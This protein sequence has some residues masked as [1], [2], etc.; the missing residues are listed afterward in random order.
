MA[1][2]PLDRIVLTLLLGGCLLVAGRA[3][4]RDH[5]EHDPWTPLALDD[6]AG[7]ATSRKIA[8]LRTERAVCRAFLGR[9]GIDATALAPAGE[10]S[11]RRDDRKALA[12]P[13]WLDIALRPG[14]A[15]ATCAIDAG[16]AWW[17]HN[18]VQPA[19]VATLGTRVVRVEH[20]G[21]ANCRRIG[22]GDEGTWSEHATGNA[23]DIAAFVLADGRRI[24]VRR[25]W[26][27][28]G[29]SGVEASAFLHMVRDS[30]CAGF[31]TVLSPDYNAAHAD[32]LHLDQARRA[33]GWSACR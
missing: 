25:D 26:R 22:G 16:L 6:P 15:Q 28:R 12:A 24:S 20:L 11:C 32:H 9:S 14:G 27:A 1:F 2:A 10:G 30:A 8:A 18:G 31:A 13:A 4:L 23:I 33:G 7:W 17:L 3:W 19:A 29:T 21:T 5:P